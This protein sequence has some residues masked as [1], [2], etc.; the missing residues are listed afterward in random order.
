MDGKFITSVAMER[1]HLDWGVMGWL[2]RPATTGAKDLVVIEVRLEPGFGHNFHKHPQQEEV[3]Y[4]VSGGVEQWVGRE[5]TTLAPGDGVFIGADVVHAS[6]NTGRETARLIAILG[7]SVG[8]EG[9]QLVE[10]YEQEPWASL[11]K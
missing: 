6:F 9:Y 11:R 5:S 8:D 10:V 2:S 4:V 7:P 3:I 1:D